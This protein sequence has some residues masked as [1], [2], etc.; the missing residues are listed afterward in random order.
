MNTKE[1]I[2]ISSPAYGGRLLTLICRRPSLPD[3]YVNF[4]R[5]IKALLFNDQYHLNTFIE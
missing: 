3:L 5:V 2:V 4:Q 1:R